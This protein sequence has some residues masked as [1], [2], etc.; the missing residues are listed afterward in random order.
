MVDEHPLLWSG[1]T[2]K[3]TPALNEIP[4]EIEPPAVDGTLLVNDT[5]VLDVNGTPLVIQTPV[6]PDAPVT[7][8]N[9]IT[10]SHD[11]PEPG[12]DGDDVDTDDAEEQPQN[13]DL[14]QSD[15][16]LVPTTQRDVNESKP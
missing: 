3:N 6:S 4:I 10:V 11:E 8:S 5:P 13:I 16:A 14:T 1:Q 7:S 15:T 2:K 9:V 12:K